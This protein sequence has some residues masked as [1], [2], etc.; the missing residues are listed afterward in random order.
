MMWDDSPDDDWPDDYGVDDGWGWHEDKP[1]MKLPQ[2]ND[3]QDV[4]HVTTIIHAPP[5]THTL[6]ETYILPKPKDDAP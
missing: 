1:A 3:T 6:I 4:M 2:S 5:F